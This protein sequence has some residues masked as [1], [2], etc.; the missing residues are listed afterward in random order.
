MNK[1]LAAAALT[2]G[3]IGFVSLSIHKKRFEEK[4]SGGHAVSVLIA[5]KDLK[6]GDVLLNADTSSRG[7]PQSYIEHRHIKVSEKDQL[8]GIVLDSDVLAGETLGWEDLI[9]K[10]SN[11]RDLSDLIVDGKRASV[12]SV[13]RLGSMAK[14]IKPGDRVDVYFTSDDKDHSKS[15]PILQRVLILAVGTE[16]NREPESEGRKNHF[17]DV[18]VSTTPKEAE[19]L[20]HAGQVGRLSLVLRNAKDTKSVEKDSGTTLASLGGKIASK[21][22]AVAKKRAPRVVRLK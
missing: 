4:M 18:T 17:T 6:K 22:K 21:P 20:V 19:N 1:K 14:L 2:S 12:I 9:S 3:V 5:S 16:M 7:I 15:L 11:Q 13:S 8:E 10:Q